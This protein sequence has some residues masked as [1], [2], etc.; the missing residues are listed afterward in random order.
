MLEDSYL[1]HAQYVLSLYEQALS[2]GGLDAVVVD[3]GRP[4]R[5]FLDDQDAP[6]RTNPLF[7]YL[8]PLSAVPGSLILIRQG[9]KPRLLWVQPQDYWHL[10]P[11]PPDPAFSA[12]FDVTI[13]AS[14]EAAAAAA[15]R[16][17]RRNERSAWLGENAAAASNLGCEANP[18]VLLNFIHWHRAYKT[19]FEV[20]C[21]R[22]ATRRGVQGHRAAA[23]GFAAG[24]SEFDLHCGYLA[25]S[26]QSESDLPY[27]NIIAFDRH[28]A[29]LHYQH[30][31]RNGAAQ[32]SL[33]IDAGGRH[34]GYAADIT[35]TYA[36][37]DQREFAALIEAM[38]ALQQRIVAEIAPGRPY[39]DLHERAHVL[40]AELL[41]DAE[42]ARGSASDLVEDGVTRAF[43]PHGLGHLLGL[44]THDVGGLMSDEQGTPS[45]PPERDPA[46]RNTRTIEIGQTFTIEPGL[47]FIDMLLQPLRSD[48]RGES[49]RWESVERLAPWGG[50]RIEDNILVTADGVV[51][52]TREAFEAAK[53]EAT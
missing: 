49:V 6:L 12:P 31:A 46:L 1:A 48:P 3:A 42:L 29:V 10:P 34:F 52:L 18:S 45:P 25:A 38:D 44:Q 40:L 22:L 28:A 7:A 33:L 21:M 9:T 13:V 17:L 24:G 14:E 35:R 47:Y 8:T 53:A 41:I 23:E 2:A 36:R 26:R 30:Y 32:G 4:H 27:P 5:Y 37:P 20:E 51:N 15:E 39:L 16:W 50:I 19:P 43:L 11:E